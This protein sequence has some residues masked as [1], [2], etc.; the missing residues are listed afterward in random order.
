MPRVGTLDGHSALIT[1]GGSGIG[2]GCAH[3]LAR[4]GASVVLAGRSAERLESAA[5]AV[6]ADL[7]G[8][9]SNAQVHTVVC[10]VT[11]EEDRRRPRF[12]PVRCPLSA[13]AVSMTLSSG[14]TPIKA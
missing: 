10:D 6:R 9:D 8:R 4:D 1:G 11:D 13:A 2:L 14:Q 7:A 3:H 5:S 12:D